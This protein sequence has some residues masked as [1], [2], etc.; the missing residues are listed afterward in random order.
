[1]MSE[2]DA[3][4]C[5]VLYVVEVKKAT[6]HSAN[7]NNNNNNKEHQVVMKIDDL[8]HNGRCRGLEVQLT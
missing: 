5:S 2:R 4:S 1:M 3:R 6:Q 7:E 8:L